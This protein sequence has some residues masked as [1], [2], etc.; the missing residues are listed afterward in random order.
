M[1]IEKIQGTHGVCAVVRS[2]DVVISDA[3]SALDVLMAAQYEA[4]TK[5]IAIDKRRIA[6]PFSS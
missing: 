3:S 6:E 1:N 2:D 4:G 5:N